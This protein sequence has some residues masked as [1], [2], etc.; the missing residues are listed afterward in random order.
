MRVVQIRKLNTQE[1]FQ[2][3]NSLIVQNIISRGF[4]SK[5]EKTKQYDE[6]FQRPITR[7]IDSSIINSFSFN[8][9]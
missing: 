5:V 4:G 6:A 7:S 9:N 2:R 3:N 8:N 1:L